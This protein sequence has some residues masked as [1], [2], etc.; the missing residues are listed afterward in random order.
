VTTGGGDSE[1]TIS[2]STKEGVRRERRNGKAHVQ[3]LKGGRAAAAQ[4]Y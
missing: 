3:T 4:V 1:I 2:K